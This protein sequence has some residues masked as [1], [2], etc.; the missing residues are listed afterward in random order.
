[1][2]SED[3]IRNCT[4]DGIPNELIIKERLEAADVLENL[5]GEVHSRPLFDSK[6]AR[7][8]TTALRYAISILKTTRI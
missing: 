7:E 2:K 1:M 3:D 5:V 4:T 6:E 8:Y